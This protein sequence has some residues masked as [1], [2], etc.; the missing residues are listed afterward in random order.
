MCVAVQCVCC[1]AALE[2]LS[3][4]PQIRDELDQAYPSQDS[5]VVEQDDRDFTPHF[6][7]E[8]GSDDSDGSMHS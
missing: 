1:W 4:L 7:P 3:W 5:S 8:Q 6:D 2:H